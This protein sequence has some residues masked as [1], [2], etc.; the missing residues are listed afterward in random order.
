MGALEQYLNPLLENFD[1]SALIDSEV[2]RIE[3]DVFRDPLVYKYFSSPRRAFFSKPQLRTSQREALNDPLE[4]SHRWNIA[5]A[6]GLKSLVEK[7]LGATLP[8][9]FQNKQLQKAMFKEHLSESGK[10]LSP[11][12]EIQFEKIVSSEMFTVYLNQLSTNSDGIAAPFIGAAFSQMEARFDSLVES[13]VSK[14]G[15]LSLTEDPLNQAMWA[16]YGESG[17]GF[18][19]GLDAQA[20]FFFSTAKERRHL[21]KR[22]KYTNDRVD[23][24][25]RNPYYLILVK[26]RDWA[27]EREWRMLKNLIDSDEIDHGPPLAVHL[28][29][30]PPHI[31]KTVHFGYGYDSTQIP[32]DIESLNRFGANPAFYTVEVDR[33]VG[34]LKS[35]PL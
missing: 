19:I 14:M 3:S 5:K 25:W 24:F 1:V 27:Y 23:N 4:M 28:L 7:H 16:H 6:D 33:S 15:I 12:E 17:K 26:S 34:V 22:V 21:L 10:T 11:L 8:S 13:L 18:V 9:V 29:N 32:K 20:D 2:E 30:V 31:I 35:V